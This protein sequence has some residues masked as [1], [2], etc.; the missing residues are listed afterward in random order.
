MDSSKQVN[1]NDAHGL[2]AAELEAIAGLIQLVQSDQGQST[3]EASADGETL[4]AKAMKAN[5]PP[6]ANTL[7]GNPSSVP[8]S[9]S[10]PP[11]N[12]N[13][14]VASN[15]PTAIRP[16]VNNNAGS[17]TWFHDL[18]SRVPL[19]SF[20]R[21]GMRPMQLD[22]EGER[23]LEAVLT[24]MHQRSCI[25]EAA[26]Y[27]DDNNWDVQDAITQYQYDEA[28]RAKDQTGTY[29]RALQETNSVT[30]Q[31]FDQ[32]L[33]QYR[34]R[35]GGG[36]R[37]RYDLPNASS[38][39]V[40]CAD[41]LRALNHWLAD[42][43]RMRGPLPE[44]PAASGS[45]REWTDSEGRYLQNLYASK[46]EDFAIGKPPDMA[47]IVEEFNKVFVGRYLPGRVKPCPA[48]TVSS[49]NAW[50]DRVWKRD[51][52]G[53]RLNL[54]QRY[55]SAMNILQHRKDEDDEYRLFTQSGSHSQTTP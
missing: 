53:N 10:T 7:L 35:E 48:R 22:T 26:W 51:E 45:D 6:H 2:T 18:L 52:P 54:Q 14:R 11:T 25:Q 40:N 1:N 39:D 8:A 55:A 23:R 3:T 49:A 21:Y 36:M 27:L 9:M 20:M 13:S 31:N 5:S 30:L 28:C 42:M 50:L 16:T 41:H 17:T 24:A 43:S 33:L 37:R 19:K 34:I 12:P 29:Q 32:G 46:K 47:R 4:V 15:Q 38:F 44:I